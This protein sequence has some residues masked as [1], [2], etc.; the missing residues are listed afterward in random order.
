MEAALLAEEP[1]L[2][3]SVN[4]IAACAAIA[5]LLGLLGTVTGMIETFGVITQFG[6]GNPKLL[7]GGISVALITTQLGLMVAVPLLLGHAFVRRGVRTRKVL[8]EEARTRILA[9]DP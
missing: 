6:T 9:V 2:D 3:R 7:S 4:L 1:V 5:P 8:L